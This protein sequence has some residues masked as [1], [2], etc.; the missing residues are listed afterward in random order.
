VTNH[1]D[2]AVAPTVTKVAV[3]LSR[4]GRNF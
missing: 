4:N 3:A 1:A 2:R